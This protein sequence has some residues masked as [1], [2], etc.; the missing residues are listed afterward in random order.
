[1]PSA[2]KKLMCSTA[3][4]NKIIIQLQYRI[5]FQMTQ[6]IMILQNQRLP[7]WL[8]FQPA[9]DHNGQYYYDSNHCK[10][11]L[12]DLY[13]VLLWSGVAK[14]VKY[15]IHVLRTPCINCNPSSTIYGVTQLLQL[16]RPPTVC[17]NAEILAHG[18][19]RMSQPPLLRD[20]QLQG[21]HLAIPARDN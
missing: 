19:A 4:I 2:G 8:F 7:F 18:L 12:S 13:T 9:T 1:M 16:E 17:C 21:P 11:T 14:L 5:F 10:H 20:D 15:I 3:F 6:Q